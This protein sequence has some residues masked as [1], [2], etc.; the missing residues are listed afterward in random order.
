M[1]NNLPPTTNISSMI[2]ALLKNTEFQEGIEHGH[3]A[4][5]DDYSGS[6]ESWTVDEPTAL[7]DESSLVSGHMEKAIVDAHILDRLAENM[8]KSVR[9]D[10]AK[11]AQD[12]ERLGQ[13]MFY[14][15]LGFLLGFIDQGLRPA[16]QA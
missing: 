13:N 2:A 14:Y 9:I 10:W 8:N 15:G 4:F 5:L 12:R 16:E 1:L 6:D 3:D 11:V 7:V